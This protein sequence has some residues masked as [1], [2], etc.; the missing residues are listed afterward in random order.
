MRADVFYR[1]NETRETS[2]G[3]IPNDWEV[4]RLGDAARLIMGQSPPS[5]T[6]NKEGVGLPF[7]Q[8]KM[9]FG[10]IY[11]SPVVYCSDPLKMAEKD[12]IL[13]SVRAPVGDVNLTPYK[14]CIGRGLGAIRFNQKTADH[15]FYFYYLQLIKSAIDRLGKGSTF[16]AIVKSDLEGLSVVVP[17]RREQQRASEILWN[18]DRAI[19]KTN[20][21]IT[22]AE[23]LKK[24]L[25]QKLLTRGIGHKEFK[26][27][28]IGR[29]P[30][31]WDASRL[32]DVAKLESGGTPS[33]KKREYWNGTVPWLK[34]GELNDG[35]IRD[36][37]ERITKLGLEKSSA[38]VFPKGT[39]LMALYGRGTVSK[40][41]ILGIDSATNQA[42]GAIL[43][44]D[45]SFEPRY[46]QHCLVF[47]RNK[48]LNQ[49]V[50]PS[51]DV[52]RTNIY[53]GTLKLFRVPIPPVREQQKIAENLSVISKKL[54]L[55]RNQ[56]AKLE[57]AKQAL[58]DLLLTG[59]VRIKVD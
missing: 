54:E 33:R 26:D 39:L 22:T 21:I 17:P 57:K 27:S 16:K 20:D 52:G 8:G 2:L 25:M 1:E 31:N 4:V 55:E 32:G 45:G 18:V 9:E 14:L 15:L 11:P 51:S 35:E 37:E 6:Y 7:L 58:M 24:A 46:M 5:S 49:L 44:K 42:I 3:N 43:P 19:Q 28:E 56:K 34:S 13:M 50:N 48:L 38:K 36:T 30:E 29:I 53:L 41:A 12:D 59:K 40:T 47:L 10:E 23:R